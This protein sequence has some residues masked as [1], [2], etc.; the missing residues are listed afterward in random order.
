MGKIK[1]VCKVVRMYF[2]L[3][4][5]YRGAVVGKGFHVAWSVTIHPPGFHAG[6]H[7]YIGPYTEIAPRTKIG[8]YSSIS[9]FVAIVGA[10]HLY[11][12]PGTPILF[13]GRPEPSHTVI[14]H[15]ALIGHGVIIM[16]G[17]TIGNGAIVGSGSV[18]TKDVPPYVIV[19]GNPAKI[20]RYRFDPDQIEVH[21]TMLTGKV[22]NGKLP[23]KIQ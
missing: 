10:D 17:V 6:D 11:D 4:T 8:N 12:V 21:E 15:D 18:V 20:I 1:A 23:A 14:G 19:G 13:S 9:S 5:K 7:V 22:V 16:R 2:L 3:R